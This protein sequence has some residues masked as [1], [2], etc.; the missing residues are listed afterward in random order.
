M[1]AHLGKLTALKVAREKKA[2]MYGDG[3]NLWLQ[4]ESESVKSWI[5][6]YAG[7]CMGLGSASVVS[8]QQAREF[9]HEYRKLRQQGIDPIEA[10]RA[11]QAQQ[12]LEAARAIT[13][14]ECAEAYIKAHRGGWRDPKHAQQWP[15][16]IAA[17]VEP[18]IGALPV[19][20]IDTGLVHKVLEPIWSAKPETAS[21]V[22]GR[23]ESILD[24]AKV[25]GYRQG[26]N[27]ARWRGHIDKLFPSRAKLRE[28][29]HLAA[30]PY[31]DVPAF[32]SGLREREGSDARAFEFT[33]LTAARSNEVLGAQW[34]EFDLDAA[35]WVVPPQRM[36]AG[37]EHRVPLSSNALQIIQDMA[38]PPHGKF[39]F[40]RGESDEPL[41]PRTLRKVLAR[42]GVED[43]TP[44]GFRS[45]YRDWAAERT[46]YP[47]HV[48]EM[49]LA[50]TIGD[51][52]EAAYRR[53]DLFN[54][55]RR[56]MNEWAQFC[57]TPAAV[58]AVI[59]IRAAE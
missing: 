35:V 41:S 21:R 44:H 23:I 33:I 10:R 22:R 50:Y 55:R 54:K 16:T 57:N 43:A 24:W 8:L 47:N 3:G 45:S 53:G 18:I 7:R 58:G 5:F 19:Q 2:G 52:V 28:V 4:V 37:R 1:S 13:F 34:D 9:A 29:K 25:R 36:K 11:Q 6:R 51:K 26:E 38:G 15:N 31:V 59:P 48:V 39:V 17:Y 32:I 27:P 46:S 42:I 40:S 12:R 30:L 20:S 56:L 49:A 14:S